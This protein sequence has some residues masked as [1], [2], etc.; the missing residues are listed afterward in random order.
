[1]RRN[2]SG[3]AAEAAGFWTGGANIRDNDLRGGGVHNNRIGGQIGDAG[4]A[5]GIRDGS[6]IPG[7]RTGDAS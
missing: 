1:M 2:G 6:N 5:D 3:A 4:V 7:N